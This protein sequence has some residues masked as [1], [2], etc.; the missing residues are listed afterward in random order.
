M[1]RKIF[2]SYKYGDSNVFPL[3]SP[4]GEFV[5]PTKVRDYIDELQKLLAADD[6]INK[7]E[8]D[9]EDMSDFKD[10]TIESKL[11][12]KIY[13]SSITIVAI[14]P[15]MKESGKAETDQWIPW[16][17][18]YSLKEHSR[19]GR[20]SRTNAVLAVVLPDKN[21]SYGYYL[22]QNTCCS[23][24]CRSLKTYTLFQILRDNMFNAKD[25]I[26][27]PCDNGDK[28]YTGDSSYIYSV[29][30]DKFKANIGYYL[31]KA[32]ELNGNIDKFNITKLVS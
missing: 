23:S 6:H 31:D 32:V 20:T 13:D 18:S 11:R 25:L 26:G 3:K 22:N 17:I 10:S 24:K 8:A 1:G 16:E 4:I 19:D 7:G 2:I 5:E 9:G 30:W 12:D 15:N 14:S 28:V 29:N 21:N 27:S